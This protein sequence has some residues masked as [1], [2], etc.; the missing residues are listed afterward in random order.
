MRPAMALISSALVASAGAANSKE[1]LPKDWSV[2]RDAGTCEIPYERLAS[3]TTDPL[4]FLGQVVDRDHPKW[5]R[6]RRYIRKFSDVRD[7]LE[8]DE[9]NR[10]EPNL[11][12]ID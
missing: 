5:R 4:L 2:C 8:K 11:L 6:H 1:R 7:C 3:Q 9:R 10:S 12:R